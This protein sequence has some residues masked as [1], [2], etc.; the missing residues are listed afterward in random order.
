MTRRSCRSTGGDFDICRHKPLMFAET[1][2]PRVFDLFWKTLTLIPCIIYFMAAAVRVECLLT[3]NNEWFGCCDWSKMGLRR[4]ISASL[5]V[6]GRPLIIWGG[7]WCKTEKK[8]FGE[9]L[10]KKL[11]G[12]SQENKFIRENLHHAPPPDDYWST[13]KGSCSRHGLKCSRIVL[14][15]GASCTP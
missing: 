14:L 6:R 11:F 5:L 7:A 2:L 1:K 4:Y 12:G 8:S 15:Q 3:T 13:P 10:E 9:L